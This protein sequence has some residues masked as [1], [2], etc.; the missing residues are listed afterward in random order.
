MHSSVHSTPNVLVHDLEPYTDYNVTVDAHVT[1][2]PFPPEP[3]TINV[4]TLAA[5]KI[6]REMSQLS[7]SQRT[8]NVMITLL[9]RNNDVIRSSWRNNDFIITLCIRLG[10][11]ARL[12]VGQ[13][14]ALE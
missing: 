8:H 13:L 12:Y 7:S 14:S 6:T 4:R 10:T 9:L 3:S 11:T 2:S 1:G 5:G